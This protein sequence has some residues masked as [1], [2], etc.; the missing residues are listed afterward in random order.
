MW[1]R[2][3]V[4]LPPCRESVFNDTSHTNVWCFQ[5][6][7]LYKYLVLLQCFPSFIPFSAYQINQ[8]T[9]HFWAR[10]LSLQHHNSKKDETKICIILLVEILV[11][12]T[13]EM[14]GRYLIFSLSHPRWN[15][16]ELLQ[17]QLVVEKVKTVSQIP[18]SCTPFSHLCTH[19]ALHIGLFSKWMNSNF[20]CVSVC[21]CHLPCLFGFFLFW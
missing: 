7:V 6:P 5:L 3:R 21:V 10:K 13:C 11:V 15:N 8:T 9:E 16:T 19:T 17:G 4:F 18:Q 2:E 12:L 1:H 14:E 20:V